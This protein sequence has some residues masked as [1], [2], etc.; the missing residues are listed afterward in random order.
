VKLS[1]QCIIS[2]AGGSDG[3]LSRNES[4]SIVI[5]GAN[6]FFA[7]KTHPFQASVALQPQAPFCN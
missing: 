5:P 3:E 6:L 2:A 7:G 1:T 4:Q